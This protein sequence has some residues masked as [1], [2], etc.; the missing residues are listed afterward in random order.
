MTETAEPIE[1]RLADFT[2]D[3]RI[4]L[5][6]LMAVV[7]GAISAIVAK[8]LVWL[9]AIFTNLTFY[10]RFSSEFLS[11]TNHHLGRFV[12]FAPVV[13]GLI[14]GLMARYGS[15]KIRGHGIPEALE[16]I[17]FGR[18]RMDVKVAVLKPLS[19]AISIG[20]GGPFGAEGPIIMTGGACGSLVAQLF[21]LS[22]A[23]RKT[24]L[25]A[26][27]AGGMSATFGTPVAA[28]LLAVELLL[29]E[30]KPRSLIPVAMASAAAA[31]TRRYILGLGPL[32]PV[33]P[34]PLA[35]GPKALLGCL[36]VGLSAG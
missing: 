19:S 7:I 15:E 23:E 16:A 36:L 26:G 5:L 31:A 22:A 35:P 33:A 28:A 20:S 29:F 14:I 32:F 34:H 13:G 21:H 17:L 9:I 18:S 12:I 2:R 11:P 3:K 27:A 25:V 30:W 4:L 24:M 6:S 10:Q 8:A 1:D